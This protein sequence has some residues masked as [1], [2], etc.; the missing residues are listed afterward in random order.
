MC[1]P[2]SNELQRPCFDSS[3]IVFSNDETILCPVE[4]SPRS[5]PYHAEVVPSYTNPRTNSMSQ[6]MTRQYHG[7]YHLLLAWGAQCDS[8]EV[9]HTLETSSSVSKMHATL[10]LYLTICMRCIRRRHCLVCQW[11][12]GTGTVCAECA[13]HKLTEAVF[14]TQIVCTDIL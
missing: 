10:K 5:I 7:C 11:T 2:S 13:W 1:S 14:E 12:C 3:C 4:E 8:C 6:F 9:S